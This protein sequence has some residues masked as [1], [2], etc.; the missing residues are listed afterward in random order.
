M[1]ILELIIFLVPTYILS[2]SIYGYGSFF[3]KHILRIEEENF[4]LISFYGVF[5]LLTISYFTNIFIAHD[6]THNTLIFL[7]GLIF[8]INE[9]KIKSVFKS[10]LIILFFIFGFL[11]FKN[12]DDFSYYHFPYILNLIEDK[13]LIGIGNLNHGFRTPSS[14]FYLQSLTFLPYLEF[15]YTNF[16]MLFFLALVN[17]YLII[18]IK[19]K[20][21][22]KK[23]KP[24]IIFNLMCILFLNVKFYRLSE[25]GT[26]LIGQILLFVITSR[27]IYFL[28]K[29]EI[30]KND[31]YAIFFITFFIITLKSYFILYFLILLL[32][33]YQVIK[34]EN[35]QYLKSFLNFKIVFSILFLMALHFKTF[36]FNTGCILYPLAITCFENFSWSVGKESA[37]AMSLWYEQWSKAGANPNFRVDDPE[38]YVQN[39]NWISNWVKMYF[40]T[41]V[42]DYILSLVVLTVLFI[43]IFREKDK[44]LE[45]KYN[46]KNIY[47]IYLILLAEWF[48]NHPAL[49]YGG[50][51]ISSCLLFLAISDYLKNKEIF[52]KKVLVYSIIVLSILLFNT[53]NIKRLT[54]EY[55]IYSYNFLKNP[56][57]DISDHHLRIKKQIQDIKS[58]TEI[59][60]IKYK[61][62]YKY[63]I[64]YR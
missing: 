63:D 4:A 35:L 31:I 43:L 7:I 64:F 39:F 6:K 14:I 57:F 21:S 23:F 49:R 44:S 1:K 25:Y 52:T 24:I 56:E 30:K 27:L 2:L 36:F 34:K 58:G 54:N 15:S 12:H 60:E 28:N 17:L 38:L 8:L 59:Q 26:D 32:V 62:N 3:K 61:K 48:F 53:R 20:F 51:G 47:F 40:F 18:D 16:F 11:I 55:Q 41:K 37:E 46:F 13:M 45:E 9:K 22:Q 19:F 33:I 50:Y 10:Q 5:F 42:S 29:K